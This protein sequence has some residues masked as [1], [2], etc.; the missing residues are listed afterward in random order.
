MNKLNLAS[1]I[2][3]GA[4]N[5]MVAFPPDNNEIFLVKVLFQSN[6]LKLTI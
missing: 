3:A 6:S 4:L 2:P 1:F 5:A